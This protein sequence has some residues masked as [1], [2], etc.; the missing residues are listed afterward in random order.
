MEI[1]VAVPAGKTKVAFLQVQLELLHMLRIEVLEEDEFLS[2]K[3]L[4]APMAFSWE[5][6]V[7]VTVLFNLVTA[8]GAEPYL[9]G[10]SI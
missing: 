9:G 8:A 1:V 7:V 3:C 10:D 2:G 6:S 4:A 5:V